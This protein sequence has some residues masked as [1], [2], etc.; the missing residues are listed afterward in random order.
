MIHYFGM[1]DYLQGEGVFVNGISG[2]M[3]HMDAYLTVVSFPALESAIL[4]DRYTRDQ[5][6]EFI[7]E[8]DG[9]PN[10]QIPEKLAVTWMRR[11]L[12]VT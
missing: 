5:W 11:I 8:S 2:E 12:E 7:Q 10:R 3:A 6:I 1:T 9:Q 4:S